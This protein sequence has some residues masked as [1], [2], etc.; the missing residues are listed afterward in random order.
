MGNRA[1]GRNGTFKFQDRSEAGYILGNRLKFYANLRDVAVLALPRGGVLVGAEI[2]RALRAPL[3]TFIVRKLGAPGHEELA[4]GAITSGGSPIINTAITKKLGLSDR[5]VDSIVRRETRH[6]TRSQVLYCAGRPMPDLKD[7]IVILVDD[8]ASTGSSLCLAVQ[9]VQQQG[10]AH[11]IVAVPVASSSALS[12]L[13][14][15][16]NEVLC[17]MEPKNFVAVSQWYLQF[18]QPTDREVCQ[19]LERSAAVA[20]AETP[21]TTSSAKISPLAV[22]QLVPR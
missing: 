21:I 20:P 18:T 3:Y 2:S 15:V 14:K 17:L 1:N 16:A 13:G 9:A 8:G 19:I 6:L 4:I 22:G 11:V 10:V 7:R 12:Q 5:T